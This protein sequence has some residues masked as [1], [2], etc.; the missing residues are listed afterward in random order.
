MSNV[1]AENDEPIH[2]SEGKNLLRSCPSVLTSAQSGESSP[3]ITISP[4]VTISPPDIHSHKDHFQ[5]FHKIKEL[6]RGL[7]FYNI[8]KETIHQPMVNYNLFIGQMNIATQNNQTILQDMK[9]FGPIFNI[10]NKGTIIN[11][12][13]NDNQSNE[14]AEAEEAKDADHTE[15]VE[16]QP[17]KASEVKP[18]H[19]NNKVKDKELTFIDCI[20][21]KETAHIL[22]KWLHQMMDPISSKNAKEKLIFLRSVSEAGTFSQQLTYKVYLSEFGQ[23][24]KSCYYY[25]MKNELRYDRGEIDKL[26][27]VYLQF[28]TQFR[29]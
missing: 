4:P 20:A 18:S 2:H 8:H 7:F 28:L 6:L 11:N 5:K 15:V 24:T 3:L 21:E 23:M 13:G 1:I 19:P 26:Y 29:K 14:Q 22:R 10:Y 27:E 17:V 25:W 12:F 9:N 16:V